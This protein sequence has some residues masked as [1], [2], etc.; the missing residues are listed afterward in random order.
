[1]RKILTALGLMSGTSGDGVDASIIKSNG[2]TE[3]NDKN[4]VE[5]IKDKYFEYDKKIVKKIHNLRDKINFL[6]DL[7]VYK[8]EIKEIERE[9]T[10]FHAKVSK[11]MINSVNVD[12][13]GFHGHTVYHNPKEKISKQIGDAKLLSQLTNKSIVYN[14][15]E[16][17]IKYGGEGAPLACIYHCAIAQQEDIKLPVVFMNIGGI[18][19]I[20]WFH[21]TGDY[22]GGRDIGPGNYLIDKWIRENSNLNYDEEGKIAKTGKVNKL[23]LEQVYEHRNQI[24]ENRSIVDTQRSLDIKNYDIGFVRGLSLEDGAATLTEYTTDLLCDYLISN[25]FNSDLPNHLVDKLVLTGGGR[26]NKFLVYKMKEKLGNCCQ[27]FMIDDYGYDGDFVE[28]QAF[29]FLAIR[30]FNKLPTSFPEFTGCDKEIIGGE[31]IKN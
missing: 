16:K 22:Y 21:Y 26:K 11:E 14:F 23:I 20:T 25:V 29:A 10:I 17:D 13:I 27:I 3:S 28:S 31:L 15:R 30:S 19:N 24:F 5:L 8:K 7:E 2:N 9:I 6:N 1:M 4:V 12:L 18:S